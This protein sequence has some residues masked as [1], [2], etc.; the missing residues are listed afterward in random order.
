ME[1]A[2]VFQTVNGARAPCCPG[3]PAGG[4]QLAAYDNNPG[5]FQ[6][7]VLRLP[8]SHWHIYMNYKLFQRMHS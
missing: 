8:G 3:Q 2:R 7:L 6:A 4:W 5:E 1:Q